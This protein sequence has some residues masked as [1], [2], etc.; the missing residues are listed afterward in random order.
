VCPGCYDITSSPTPSSEATRVQY[1]PWGTPC[2]WRVEVRLRKGSEERW[3]E[4]VP[5]GSQ[6]IAWQLHD[7]DQRVS[8]DEAVSEW[9]QF[10]QADEALIKD[11][12]GASP[13]VNLA[14]GVYKVGNLEQNLEERAVPSQSASS[15]T[16]SPPIAEDG[17]SN[18]KDSS[19]HP[20]LKSLQQPVCH[21]LI[22]RRHI[23]QRHL[24]RN[25]ANRATA[26]P[27]SKIRLSQ[28]LQ[29]RSSTPRPCR[30]SQTSRHCE[31]RSD[32]SILS[33]SHRC[34]SEPNL[35]AYINLSS[36]S[37][38]FEMLD[39]YVKSDL[40]RPVFVTG[41]SGA[42]RTAFLEAW[43]KRDAR[44]GRTVVIDL[45]PKPASVLIA[46]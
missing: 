23:R 41:P 29:I 6:D 36:R 32:P 17:A 25:N 30:H 34:M 14:T 1:D 35:N 9:Q 11:R 28:V 27:R 38:L 18:S 46:P 12:V 40:K 20:P 16:P 21:L 7:H 3:V 43:A 31:P 4:A 37:S 39:G 8:L 10:I 13:D 24:E 26:H 44:H 2:G 19:S 33:R 5:K 42:G 15:T 22:L 45:V